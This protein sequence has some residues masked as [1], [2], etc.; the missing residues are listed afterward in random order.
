MRRARGRFGAPALYGALMSIGVRR[1]HVAIDGISGEWNVPPR[2]QP[3]VILYVHG[4]GFC[5]CS[6][7][8]HRPI[9]A[10]LA[11]YSRR[12]VLN[13]EYRLAPEHRFPAA[14]DDVEAAYGF[15]RATVGANEAIALAG[16]SAG[17]NLVL[18]LALRLSRRGHPGPSC[19][20]AFSPWTDLAVTGASAR[21]NDGA[22]D[23]FCYENL[24][25]FA[26]VYLGGQSAVAP[27]ASPVYAD[28]GRMPP[29]LLHVGASELLLDDATRVHAHM[30]ARNRSSH[31][32]VYD[33]V[34]HCWQMLVPWVPEAAQSL[35]AAAEFIVEH[36]RAN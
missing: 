8:T 23:M 4:G 5:S 11:R 15:L 28:F 33:G 32:E 16:D 6:P 34:A 27:D 22:D 20:V 35:R 10:A 21:A 13:L 2:L 36:N 3:G 31:L 18:G 1:E 30:L 29:V 12:R 19:V 17:G 7:H 26:A 24:A 14:L 25:D 9:V